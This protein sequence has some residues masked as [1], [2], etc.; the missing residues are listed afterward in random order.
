MS[1][2]PRGHRSN[3]AITD[4]EVDEVLAISNNSTAPGPDGITHAMIKHLSPET[5]KVLTSIYSV[6]FNK[7]YFPVS[8]K[9]ANMVMIPKAIQPPTGP[10]SYK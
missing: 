9:Y 8:S 3:N 4:K 1:E 5:S 10:F 2:D 6:C 7:G